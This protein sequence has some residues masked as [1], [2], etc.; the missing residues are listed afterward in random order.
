MKYLAREVSSP[1]LRTKLTHWA[2]IARHVAEHVIAEDAFLHVLTHHGG[3]DRWYR[4]LPKD[5]SKGG[6][7]KG[8]SPKHK[9]DAGRPHLRNSRSPEAPDA[10][11]GLKIADKVLFDSIVTRAE[12]GRELVC[13]LFDITE[14]AHFAD[15][16]ALIARLQVLAE[17]IGV[18]GTANHRVEPVAATAVTEKVAA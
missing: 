2:A 14:S 15:V 13:V 18:V 12:A 1:S 6:R 8:Y 3:I 9:D 5:A 16:N 4:K 17:Y 10:P 7:P 11:K